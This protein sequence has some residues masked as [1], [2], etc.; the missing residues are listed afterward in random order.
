MS[1]IGT[2]AEQVTQ[3]LLDAADAAAREQG[4]DRTSGVMPF[5]RAL[6]VFGEVSAEL[7]QADV[8]GLADRLPVS[9]RDSILSELSTCYE[10]LDSIRGGNQRIQEFVR[11]VDA[12]HRQVWLGGLGY[13][14]KSLVSYQMKLARLDKL[15]REARGYR[16]EAAAV[17]EL[18]SEAEQERAEVGRLGEQMREL[19]AGAQAGSE[20]RIAQ[21]QSLVQ[22]LSG[23]AESGRDAQGTIRSQVELARSKSG[24]ASDHAAAAEARLREATTSQQALEAYY[25]KVDEYEAKLQG[26]T[27]KAGTTIARHEKRTNDL[28]QRLERIQDDIKLKLQKATGYTLFETFQKRRESIRVG[29]ARWFWVVVGAAAAYSV[30]AWFLLHDVRALDVAFFLKL[31]FSLP[32]LWVVGFAVRQ[33]GRERR[34]EE[35][36]AFKSAISLSLSA[37]RELVEEGLKK[38]TP[39]EKA[40][41]A[42][43]L[44]DS[45]GAVF[46]SPMERVFGERR[47]RMPTDTKVI[48]ELAEALKPVAELVK[49]VPR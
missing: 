41:Y 36:Y 4:F 32:L 29:L 19:L 9:V 12:L 21:I 2:I 28:L 11:Q 49:V 14:T 26:I 38:L 47:S 17:S 37:Y 8:D 34:L 27:E 20:E 43:F 42:T 16:K 40:R 5:E 46:D 45:V 13:R 30:L 23:F 10:T 22:E 15:T 24:E 25:G 39:E 6:E 44:T 1:E 33:Y 35:E 31:G 7:A 3:E 48:A 18:R